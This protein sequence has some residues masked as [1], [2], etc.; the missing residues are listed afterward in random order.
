LFLFTYKSTKNH[1]TNNAT[2]TTTKKQYISANILA[3]K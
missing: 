2:T 1:A 3:V